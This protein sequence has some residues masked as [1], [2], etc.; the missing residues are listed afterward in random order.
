M[1]M[2]TRLA[3]VVGTLIVMMFGW[4]GLAAESVQ[5]DDAYAGRS[6][7]GRK[8]AVAR[9]GGSAGTEA[10]VEAALRGRGPWSGS[11]LD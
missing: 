3:P 6:E 8:K 11:G 5:N 7:D 9:H 1:I 10:A 4:P 2:H